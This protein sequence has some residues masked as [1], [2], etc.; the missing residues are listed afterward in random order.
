MLKIFTVRKVKML[1]NNRQP[2]EIK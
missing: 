1:G 2:N